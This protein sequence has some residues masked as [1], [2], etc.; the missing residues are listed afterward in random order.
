MNVA[1]PSVRVS[2]FRRS[3]KQS[4][5][6]IAFDFPSQSPR[7]G[8]RCFVRCGLAGESAGRLPGRV[9]IPSVRVSVFRLI[10]F[11]TMGCPYHSMMCR[12]PLGSGLG[13][14]SVLASDPFRPAATLWVAIPSVR[15]SC[16]VAPYR[17]G[18]DSAVSPECV[19]IP[20]VRVSV[21]RRYGRCVEHQTSTPRSRR[22]PLGSGL[23]VSSSPQ[24]RPPSR[25][26]RYVAGRNPLG[27]VL[28]VSSEGEPASPAGWQRAPGVA[29]PSVRVSVFRPFSTMRI[30]T[31]VRFCCRNPLGSGLGVSSQGI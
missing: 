11:S 7:F 4:G 3:R 17:M 31:A 27:S 10:T 9:A 15:V 24:P 5:F 19:A 13:V 30:R 29:I 2:V 22:N 28:G 12:N 20:S 25:R 23:G 14:S 21:F 16:F 1:I 8:S 18:R 26:R 6:G